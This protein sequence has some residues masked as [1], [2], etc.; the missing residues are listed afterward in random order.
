VSAEDKKLL[1]RIGGDRNALHYDDAAANSS[2][3]DGIF[4]QGGIRDGVH[5]CRLGLPHSGAS[6]R[7]HHRGRT[8]VAAREDKPIADPETRVARGGATVFLKGTA[9]TYTLDSGGSE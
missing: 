6:R 5:E 8:V 3:F 1:T 2:R 9:V 4:V 7:R